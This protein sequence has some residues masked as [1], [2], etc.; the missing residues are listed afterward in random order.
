MSS[1]GFEASTGTFNDT[2]QPL[3]DWVEKQACG[4]IWGSFRLWHASHC[5]MSASLVFCRPLE[6]TPSLTRSTCGT[7]VRRTLGLCRGSKPTPIERFPPR[8][9][10][11]CR[12]TPTLHLL[13]RPRVSP[14]LRR[15]SPMLRL[16]QDPFLC[17]S[18]ALFMRR[19]ME[20]PH[21]PPCAAAP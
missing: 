19:K 17:A 12:D 16:R 1:K 14:R 10:R 6:C 15:C 11:P 8:L 4:D 7:Q 2:L 5:V 3:L 18:F 20:R 13:I 21:R 9:Q